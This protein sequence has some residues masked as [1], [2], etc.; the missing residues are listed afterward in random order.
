MP[1]NSE[2]VIFCG[3]ANPELSFDIG[4]SLNKNLGEIEV[5]HFSDGEIR[6]KINS[7]VRGKD[8]FILQPTVYP[9]SENIMRLLLIIDAVKRASAKRITAVMPYY[10]YSRQEKKSQGR[11]PIAAK[12]I[13]NLLYT[14]GVDRIVAMDLHAS[15]IQGFFDIPLDHLTA[16]KIL[17]EY[18][19]EKKLDECVIVSPDAGGTARARSFARILGSNLAI[20]DKRRPRPNEAEIMNIIG[21]VEGKNAIIVDDI[22]DTAGTMT[23]AAEALV[24]NGA[25]K[26]YAACTHGVLSGPAVDRINDSVISELVITDTVPL[27]EKN[28]SNIKVLSVAPILSEA[29]YRVHNDYSISELFL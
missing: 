2:L 26:V 16:V 4:K 14:S 10:A 29:I 1:K 7:N 15:A 9:Y 22:I 8:I 20:I 28:I 13:A 5:G 27:G 6:I 24:K 12:L 25:K 17:A 19:I 3:G 23:K 18:F 21:D 11:E